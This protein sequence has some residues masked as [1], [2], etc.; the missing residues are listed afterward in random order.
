[1]LDNESVDI[2]TKRWLMGEL[3]GIVSTQIVEENEIGNVQLSESNDDIMID[4]YN[5]DCV[6]ST[7]SHDLSGFEQ[8]A[9]SK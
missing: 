8:D 5:P 4:N 7:C 2:V 9:M 1:M 3:G 6:N